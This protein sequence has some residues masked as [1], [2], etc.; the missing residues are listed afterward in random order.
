MS[1]S[2]SMVLRARAMLLLRGIRASRSRRRGDIG[3]GILVI[4]RRWVVGLRR[5]RARVPSLAS[6]GA[7][8]QYDVMREWERES[9]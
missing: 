2:A 3:F 8:L 9:F 7:R 6:W 4:P 1:G 5:L